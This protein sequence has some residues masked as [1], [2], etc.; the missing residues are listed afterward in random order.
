MGVNVGLRIVTSE[1]FVA[2][3]FSAVSGCDAALPKFLW[4]FLLY[5]GI[6]VL[7][8][9]KC[10]YQLSVLVYVTVFLRVRVY[11]LSTSIFIFSTVE[12]MRINF[13]CVHFDILFVYYCS[14]FFLFSFFLLFI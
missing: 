7:L 8:H 14:F 9:A 3:L 10:L 1:D 11:V 12:G 5:L 2:Y 13:A 6:M 4:D